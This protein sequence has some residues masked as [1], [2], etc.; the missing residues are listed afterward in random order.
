[1]PLTARSGAYHRR[2]LAVLERRLTVGELALRD[3]LTE[4][5]FAL[6]EADVAVLANVNR[7]DDLA[8]LA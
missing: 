5:E 2:T 1:M 4:L 6:V 3:A 7:P 8:A